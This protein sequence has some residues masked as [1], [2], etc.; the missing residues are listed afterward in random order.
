MQV[1]GSMLVYHVTCL[2]HADLWMAI[3]VNGV[4]MA[5]PVSKDKPYRW[6][7]FAGRGYIAFEESTKWP[8]SAP[9]P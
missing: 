4:N 8:T 6:E 7:D 9:K 1:H 2:T 5:V 3:C